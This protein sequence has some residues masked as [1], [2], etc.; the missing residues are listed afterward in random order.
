MNKKEFEEVLFKKLEENV[1][2]ITNADKLSDKVLALG[3]NDGIEFVIEL[4][5]EVDF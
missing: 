1:E 4:L 2:I 5:S 3:M